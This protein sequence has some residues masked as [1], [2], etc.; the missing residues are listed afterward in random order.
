MGKTS[1][2]TRLPMMTQTAEYA[3][4]ALAELAKI[5]DD[6]SLRTSDLAARTRVPEAYLGKVLRRLVESGVLRAHKG[7]GGGFTL[8]RPPE[9]VRFVEVLEALDSMPSSKRCA[10]GLS[11]CNPANPC[12]LHPA[13]A[14]LNELL[15]QWAQDTTLADVCRGEARKRKRAR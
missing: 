3:M 7:H 4:R 9:R 8:A 10:F 6:E 15:T 1:S 11:R 13:W 2:A 12:P 5:G 14:R